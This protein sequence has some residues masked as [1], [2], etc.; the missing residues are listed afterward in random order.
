M[1]AFCRW[2]RERAAHLFVLGSGGFFFFRSL[3]AFSKCF[4]FALRASL[5]FLC[6]RDNVDYYIAIVFSA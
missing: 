1:V 6:T 3:A 2:G 4:V 5:L